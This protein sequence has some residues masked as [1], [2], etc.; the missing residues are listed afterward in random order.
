MAQ[1]HTLLRIDMDPT[2]P[3]PESLAAIQALINVNQNQ[4]AAILRGITEVIE[5]RLN[6]I[7]K[8]KEGE[9]VE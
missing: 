5:R 4:E 3:V 9:K 2:K 1:V 6:Q 7:T 8:Q